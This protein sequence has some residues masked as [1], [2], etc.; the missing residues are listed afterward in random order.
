ML[1]SSHL[2]APAPCQLS[3]GQE[4]TVESPLSSLPTVMLEK[5]GGATVKSFQ[6]SPLQNIKLDVQSVRMGRNS[7]WLVEHDEISLWG[8]GLGGTLL[9]PHLNFRSFTQSGESPHRQWSFGVT[10]NPSP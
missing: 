9:S 7:I 3:E 5:G 10:L 6:T 8:G 4:E 1:G 2:Q